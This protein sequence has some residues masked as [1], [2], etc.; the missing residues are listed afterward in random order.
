[1][2]KHKDTLRSLKKIHCRATACQMDFASAPEDFQVLIPPIK[3]IKKKIDVLWYSLYQ[4]WEMERW[5]TKGE[6]LYDLWQ[7]HSMADRC[8]KEG[9]FSSFHTPE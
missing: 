1:L 8:T 4:D 7:S 6:S 9:V 5:S 3:S 2:I